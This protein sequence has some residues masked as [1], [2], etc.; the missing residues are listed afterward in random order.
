MDCVR[1]E[2]AAELFLFL[3]C[4]PLKLKEA[5]RLNSFFVKIAAV[6]LEVRLACLGSSLGEFVYLLGPSCWLVSL[7]CLPL[8]VESKAPARRRVLA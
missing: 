8:A 3:G 1:Q 5:R 7:F 2:Q 4:R 6:L